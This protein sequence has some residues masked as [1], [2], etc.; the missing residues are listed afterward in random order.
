ME[1]Y[2]LFLPPI[3]LAEKGTKNWNKKEVKEYFEWFQSAK[4]MR[5]YNFPEYIDYQ[6][7]NNTSEDL[8]VLSKM[9]FELLESSQ[10][11]TINEGSRIKQQNEQG[12]A[13]AADFGL[14]FSKFLEE[15]KPHLKW[16]VGK[17]PKKYHV[18]NLPMLTGFST[19]DWDFIFISI[20][21][22]G[23]ALNHLQKP[24]DW[25]TFYVEIKNKVL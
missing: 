21:K 11:H 10:F 17:G 4:G 1:S 20:Q 18:Y 2:P 15:D 25:A 3:H 19:P 7:V 14:L 13:L 23:F 16:I 6:L 22:N 24:Y 8:G 5:V 12:L 9:V